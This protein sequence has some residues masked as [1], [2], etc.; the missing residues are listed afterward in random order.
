M[1]SSQ[2]EPLHP[3]AD[4]GIVYYIYANEEKGCDEQN[5]FVKQT[6]TYAMRAKRMT[7]TVTTLLLREA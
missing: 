1:L 5:H 7:P 4:H 2:K 6:V 3:F